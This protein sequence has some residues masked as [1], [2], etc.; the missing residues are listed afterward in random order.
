MA[1]ILDTPCSVC[2]RRL[3]PEVFLGLTCG[4][5]VRKLHREIIGTTS[6]KKRKGVR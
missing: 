4:K 2:G 1:S 5:C 3:G 6:D